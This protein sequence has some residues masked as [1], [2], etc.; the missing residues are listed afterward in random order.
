MAPTGISRRSRWTRIGPTLMIGLFLAYIDRSNLSVALPGVADELGFAE[1]NFAINASFALTIFLVGY[2]LANLL[3]GV[4]TRSISARR[5]VIV[6][7][8]V[9]SVATVLTGLYL[10]LALLVVYRLVLGV[11]EGVYWPQQSR[12]VRAW[13]ADRELSRAN[14]LIQFYGQYLSLGI[15][16]LALSLLYPVVGWRGLFLLTGLLGLVIIVPLYLVNLRDRPAE[17]EALPEESAGGREKLTFAQ[18][19]GAPFLL[20][21]L[22]YLCQGMLFWGITLWIPLAVEDLEFSGSSAAITSALPYLAAVLLAVPVTAFS[23]RTRRQ[24]AIAAIG[25]IG[26]G[27]LLMA[28]PTVE[29]GGGKMALIIVTMAWYA[30]SY[31]PNIWAIIQISVRPRAVSSAA[32]IIN[33]IGSGGGGVI[34]GW[35]VG[36]LLNLTDSYQPGFIALG[37]LSFVGGAALLW[38]GRLLAGRPNLTDTTDTARTST[39]HTPEAPR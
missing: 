23:D 21:V 15:G 31:T 10:T 33:G 24:R 34:A 28:L 37:V 5:I 20:L 6:A 17:D 8:A 12:F 19:G 9:W 22:S 16:F 25:Q 32:G 36:L 1:D 14:A 7:V 3:G 26:P 13:F 35:L 4:T 38:H 2:A 39:P 30:S 11:A 18:V 27:L 29:S